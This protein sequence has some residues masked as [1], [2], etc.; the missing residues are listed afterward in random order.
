MLPN[1]EWQIKTNEK[2]IY[3]TFDDGPTPEVTSWVS[4]KLEEYEAKATF[5]CVGDNVLKYPEIPQELKLRGHAIGNHT[6]HHLSALQT[7]WRSYMDDIIAAAPLTSTKLFRPPYGK[8]TP[9]HCIALKRMGY[10]TIMWSFLSYDFDPDINKEEVID[11]MVTNVK[12]GSLIIFHDSIKA[13]KNLSYLLPA[14]LDR[15]SEKGYSF[16][17]L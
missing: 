5:F 11:M 2:T 6:M 7:G 8:L 4:D 9:F 14:T 10:K 1:T 16:S 17:P 3:L 13:Q 15:L 12:P